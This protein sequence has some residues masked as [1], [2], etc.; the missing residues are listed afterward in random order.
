MEWRELIGISEEDCMK[1]IAGRAVEEF[2]NQRKTLST[3]LKTAEKELKAKGLKDSII[4]KILKSI[5]D[6]AKK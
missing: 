6:E 3:F 2:K 5:E 1:G 4:Q